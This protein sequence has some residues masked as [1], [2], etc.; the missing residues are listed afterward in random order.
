MQWPSDSVNRQLI[1]DSSYSGLLGFAADA[2]FDLDD[3]E[4]LQHA[5]PVADVLEHEHEIVVMLARLKLHLWDGFQL[6][7]FFLDGGELG[8]FVLGES[9]QADIMTGGLNFLQHADQAVLV[10]LGQFRK[11]VVREHIGKLGLFACV[12]LKVHRDLLAAE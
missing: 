4:Q 7:N 10:D 2:E 11:V 5:Q 12:I 3:L 8:N 1:D 6:G 9:G